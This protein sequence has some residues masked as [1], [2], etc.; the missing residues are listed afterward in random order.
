[1][2]NAELLTALTDVRDRLMPLCSAFP[3]ARKIVADINCELVKLRALEVHRR[4]L[5]DA[6][7]TQSASPTDHA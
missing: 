7:A 1:M 5:D 3:I 2:T 4:T 6:A